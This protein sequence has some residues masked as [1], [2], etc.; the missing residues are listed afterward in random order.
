MLPSPSDEKGQVSA[1]DVRTSLRVYPATKDSF[2]GM[3]LKSYCLTLE[4]FLHKEIGERYIN[5]Q[6]IL[7]GFVCLYVI[8]HAGVDWNLKT[9]YW[10]DREVELPWVGSQ[11]YQLFPLFRY[12]V[13]Q[14]SKIRLLGFNMPITVFT[15][16]KF[17][18][19]E[20]FALVLTVYLTIS[21]WRQLEIF[22]NNRLG[23]AMHNRSS[24]E[25][26]R[27]WDPVYILAHKLNF[28]IDV[29]KQIC[30]PALCI[31]FGLLFLPSLALPLFG[32]DPTLLPVKTDFFRK[33]LVVS[34]L[35]QDAVRKLSA[36]QVLD[37]FSKTDPARRRAFLSMIAKASAED[38]A[39][40]S[41][42]N[43]RYMKMVM[44]FGEGAKR[45]LSEPGDSFLKSFSHFKQM[46]SILMLFS[47]WF[48]T[49]GAALFL[50]AWLENRHRKQYFL[51]RVAN[52]F[53]MEGTRMQQRFLTPE[54]AA[55]F[56]RV[57][58]C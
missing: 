47:V 49:G 42:E 56:S 4:V 58:K 45:L 50:K 5:W 7:I 18:G 1:E 51:D 24:G 22:L 43:Q 34:N 11:H 54:T 37:Q 33:V 19:V 39:S 28:Q 8:G 13:F 15:D 53:D 31:V 44:G 10:V 46:K 27:V 2:W 9:Y 52:E 21:E 30:E 48:L 38:I 32:I 40:E 17:D 6:R 55:G 3:I 29:V 35:S 25:P 12:P 16:T 57:E 23:V 14:A 20:V 26:Y 41:P 36:E